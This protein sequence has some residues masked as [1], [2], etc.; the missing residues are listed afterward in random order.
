MKDLIYASKYPLSIVFAL[1]VDLFALATFSYHMIWGELPITYGVFYTILAFV[2]ADF[3]IC[4]HAGKAILTKDKL[5]ITYFFPWNSNL[6]FD[7]STFQSIETNKPFKRFFSTVYITFKDNRKS[8]FNIQSWYG[9]F[10]GIEI[11]K[12][13]FD[14]IAK[15]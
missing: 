10:N 4:P 8:A 5:L 11:L 15:Q 1:V 9:G 6:E 2:L 14:Q 12:E 3:I 7:I 13:K